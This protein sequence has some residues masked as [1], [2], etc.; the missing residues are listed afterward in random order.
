MCSFLEKTHNRCISFHTKK[1]KRICSISKEHGEKL[2][3]HGNWYPNQVQYTRCAIR[4]LP[5]SYV[6]GN[7]YLYLGRIPLP[8]SPFPLSPLEHLPAEE[9]SWLL[10]AVARNSRVAVDISGVFSSA[11]RVLITSWTSAYARY[12]KGSNKKCK[13]KKEQPCSRWKR[14]GISEDITCSGI[15][16]IAAADA[17]HDRAH[18]RAAWHTMW[19][20]S[21][22]IRA[23]RSV[24]SSIPIIDLFTSVVRAT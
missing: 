14:K 20:A 24:C 15:P 6:R 8:P 1:K 17:I 9:S 4:G 11:I 19:R 21:D 18:T 23:S 13:N 16:A 22:I 7:S 10:T 2:S 12:N 5:F 3:W